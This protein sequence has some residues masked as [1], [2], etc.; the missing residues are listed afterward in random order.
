[1]TPLELAAEARQALEGITPDEW[2]WW[3]DFHGTEHVIG[4]MTRAD[5]R[6]VLTAPVRVRRMADA[7]DAQEATIANLRWEVEQHSDGARQATNDRDEARAELAEA[8]ATIAQLKALEAVVAEASYRT[9]RL[10]EKEG[11]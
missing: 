8:H 10:D 4:C 9:G 1:M 6:F 3:E 5:K 7:L 2:S 11:A